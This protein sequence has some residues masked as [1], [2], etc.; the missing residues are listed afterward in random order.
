MDITGNAEQVSTGICI[1]RDITS[2][3]TGRKYMIIND[4]NISSIKGV[5]K[6]GFKEMPGEIIIDQF[7]RYCYKK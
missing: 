2:K 1:I 4:L 7:K 3:F 6:A 5:I